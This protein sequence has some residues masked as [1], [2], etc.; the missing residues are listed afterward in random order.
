VF[1]MLAGAGIAAEAI[2]RGTN[3]PLADVHSPQARISLTQLMTVCQNALRL[4]TDRHLPYRIGA[5]IHISTY[6]MYG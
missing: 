3:I 5:S 6:G 4:S 1:D 2:L